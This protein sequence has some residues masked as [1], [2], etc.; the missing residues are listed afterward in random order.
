MVVV[1][2]PLEF[3]VDEVGRVERTGFPEFHRLHSGSH[4]VEVGVGTQTGCTSTDQ[5]EPEVGVFGLRWGGRVATCRGEQ[6]K[7]S[8]GQ[9][10]SAHSERSLT[11][12]RANVVLNIDIV[13]FVSP[14]NGG[15]GRVEVAD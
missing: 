4:V 15:I 3:K 8:H 2:N 12:E 7:Q 14:G 9:H 13:S 10:R 11:P 1:F 5:V 6:L